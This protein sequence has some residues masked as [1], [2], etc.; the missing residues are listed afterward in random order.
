MR[1]DPGRLQLSAYPHTLEVPARFSD[2]DPQN[3]LNNVA[4][5]NFYEEGRAHFNRRAFAQVGARTGV[6]MMMVNVAITYLRE[7]RYPGVLTVATGVLRLGSSSFTLGQALFQKSECI[8]VCESVTVHLSDGS[9]A[10]LP[11][12]FRAALGNHMVRAQPVTL[13]ED[14]G[15]DA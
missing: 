2:L 6:R 10:A 4:I 15:A 3:H 1:P 5:G 14:I 9:P 8:G 13:N 7:G 11:G 12:E